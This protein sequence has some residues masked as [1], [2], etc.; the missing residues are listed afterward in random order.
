MLWLTG[1]YVGAHGLWLQGHEAHGLGSAFSRVPH[2]WGPLQRP[3]T[4]QSL[5]CSWTGGS[6]VEKHLYRSRFNQAAE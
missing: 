3:A 1:V 5:S 4:P 2:P 6:K